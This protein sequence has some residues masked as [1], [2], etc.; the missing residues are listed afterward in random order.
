VLVLRDYLGF[1]ARETG[2]LFTYIGVCIVIVQAVLIRHIV[3]RFGE[4]GAMGLGGVLLASGQILTVLAV[5][6]LLP[7][8]AWPLVQ[9]LLATT[10]ICFGFAVASP[11]L[12]SIAS[13]VAGRSSRGGSLG[14]VQGFGSLGQ[15][16]GLVVAGPLYD[17]GGTSYP[18]S[19]GALVM[20][21]ML[22]IL[23]FLVRPVEGPADDR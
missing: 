12:S 2:W 8:N 13:K 1:G 15:V 19:F 23:P 4:I 9:T 3:V 11:A 18:F 10:A 5:A 16:I 17:L 6:G 22:A 14:V 21:A 20:F 7:G